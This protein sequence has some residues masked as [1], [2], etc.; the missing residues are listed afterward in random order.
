MLGIYQF[1]GSTIR[2]YVNQ[3]ERKRQIVDLSSKFVSC[4][5]THEVF[6]RF[7]LVFMSSRHAPGGV[8]STMRATYR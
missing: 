7:D 2:G 5:S 6:V 8:R 1:G 4:Y 3:H